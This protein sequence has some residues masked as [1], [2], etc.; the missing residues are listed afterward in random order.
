M[1]RREA[2]QRSQ[3]VAAAHDGEFRKEEGIMLQLSNVT[4]ANCKEHRDRGAWQEMTWI[5][6]DQ[7]SSCSCGARTQ[8]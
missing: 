7:V 5:T 4:L 6:E 1:L 2:E 8:A 3:G